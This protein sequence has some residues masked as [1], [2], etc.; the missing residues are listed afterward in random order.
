M[1][2]T[3]VTGENVAAAD[4]VVDMALT[5]VSQSLTNCCNP[6]IDPPATPHAKRWRSKCFFDGAV[7]DIVVVD[8]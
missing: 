2:Y 7:V 1:G 4:V 8:A 3:S 6:V 5:S